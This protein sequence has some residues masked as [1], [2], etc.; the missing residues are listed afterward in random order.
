MVEQV[1]YIENYRQEV[2]RKEGRQLDGEAAAREWIDRF[3]ASFPSGLA[4][5]QGNC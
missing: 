3:A 2:L 4:E 5:L 1:C